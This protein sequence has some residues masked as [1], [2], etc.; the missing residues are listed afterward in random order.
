VWVDI[1]SNDGTLL[2]NVPDTVVGIGVD[3]C[4][5]AKEAEQF[6]DFVAQAPWGSETADAVR[7]L[8][9]PAKVVTCVA[10]FYDLMNP[11]D[12]LANVHGVLADD[13]VFV[14]QMS[15]TPLMVDQLAFD[16]ICHEHARYYTLTTLTRVLDE[17]GF[18]VV[19]AS[20]NA[21]NG[22]SMRVLAQRVDG[23]PLGSQPWRDVARFRIDSLR[24]FEAWM[25]CNDPVVWRTFAG[26]IERLRRL[27]RTFI[28]K[29]RQDG[30]SVWA[31]GASTKGNTL[32]QNFGLD[33]RYITAIAER[34]PAKFGLRTVGTD[35]P[36][37]SEDEMRKANPDFM[38]VLPWHFKDSILRREKAFLAG[39]GKF[40]FPFPEI[41]II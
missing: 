40:I 35:I 32:L 34:S 20:L 22:G 37:V 4:E 41:E 28:E 16:N 19:D 36:I 8:Y 1:A 30:A 13:G 9:G 18:I 39:G 17:A 31:Y 3:P 11:T 29:A 27:T 38:L 15:Y 25:D 7:R 24:H 14:L 10:M 6:A 26:R 2:S 5:F 12:F 33:H 21:V 23:R